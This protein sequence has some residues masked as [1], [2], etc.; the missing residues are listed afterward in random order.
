VDRSGVLPGAA[1]LLVAERIAGPLAPRP[2]RPMLRAAYAPTGPAR[3]GLRIAW[4]ASRARLLIAYLAP[5]VPLAVGGLFVANNE[6]S[7]PQQGLA[8]RLAFGAAL[9]VLLASLAHTLAVRRPTWPWARSL[10]WSALRRARADAIL[11]G[12]AA[13]PPVALAAALRPAAAVPVLAMLPL[14][15]ALAAGALRRAPERRSGAAG[16]VLVV[17]LFAVGVVALVPLLAAA[18]LA[19]TPWAIAAAAERERGLRVSRW[20]DRHHLAVGDPEA[21]SA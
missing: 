3:I 10:P 8:L 1:L 4:R 11:L 21:W 17:G 13:L 6:L 2:H 18:A 9:V 5:V 20:L 15:A 14:A 7:A 16:E 12:A 19:A